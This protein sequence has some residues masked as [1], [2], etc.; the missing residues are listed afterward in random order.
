[1]N[2]RTH[3]GTDWVLRLSSLFITLIYNFTVVLKEL[4]FLIKYY[5]K[6]IIYRLI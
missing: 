5:S 4:L 1:M 2:C 6:I 3:F